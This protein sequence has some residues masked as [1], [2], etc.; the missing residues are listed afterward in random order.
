MDTLLVHLTEAVTSGKIDRDTPYPPEMA[1]KDGASELTVKALETGIDPKSILE[2]GLLP[3]MS[4]IGDS[5]ARGE[6][7][8]PDMLIAAR[9]MAAAMKHLQPY[10]AAGEVSMKGVLIL[11][12]VEG[13]LHDIGKNLVKM[14]V[15]GNGWQVVDL[16]TDAGPEKFV[17]AVN[18]NPGSVVGMSA[19]L[20]TTMLNM[21]SVV[22]ALRENDEKTKIFIGGAPVSQSFCD[23]IGAD[24]YFP[25]P[26]SFARY[27]ESRQKGNQCDD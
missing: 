26:H 4:R 18:D 3:G 19:L 15:E 7:F 11:G 25:D 23:E 17:T 14:I 12:T 6:A 5:F 10:F 9:A 1:G 8:I 13:D 21:K 16:G 20:T 24:G 27:L 22:D 2:N